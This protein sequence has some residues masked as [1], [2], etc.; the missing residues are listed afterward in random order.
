MSQYSEY[1]MFLQEERELSQR[2]HEFMGDAN[3]FSDEYISETH[4]WTPENETQLLWD[5]R[6]QGEIGK[7]EA[8]R[9]KN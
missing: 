8:R 6:I 9:R 3:F 7:L 5:Y 2:I 4:E 1:E